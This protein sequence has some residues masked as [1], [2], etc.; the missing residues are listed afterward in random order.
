MYKFQTTEVYHEITSLVLLPV[1][2]LFPGILTSL[3]S[4]NQSEPN[5]YTNQWLSATAPIK[6]HP[7]IK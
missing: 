6:V 5:Q 4:L 1:Q 7:I 3:E 2:M